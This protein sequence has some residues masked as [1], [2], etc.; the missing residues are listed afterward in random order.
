MSRLLVTKSAL[1]SGNAA[2]IAAHCQQGARPRQDPPGPRLLLQLHY[3]SRPPQFGLHAACCACVEPYCAATVER[4]ARSLPLRGPT[5]G[6]RR[7]GRYAHVCG[8]AR[9]CLAASPRDCRGTIGGR[10]QRGPVRRR[11][12][13][14]LPGVD[15]PPRRRPLVPKGQVLL[16]RGQSH[17]AS[18]RGDDAHKHRRSRARSPTVARMFARSL[19]RVSLSLS[20]SFSR[21]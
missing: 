10:G 11:R 4:A 17:G 16:A 3:R 7:A 9:A 1:F 12:A 6:L 20:A 2:K 19:A 8:V 5:Q 13:C 14:D 18:C 21:T 15:V